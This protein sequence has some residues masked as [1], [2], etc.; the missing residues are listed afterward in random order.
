MTPQQEED[1]LDKS[2][3]LI[4]IPASWYLDD[5]PPMIFIKAAPNSHGFARPRHLGE[6]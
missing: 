2:T 5:L 1:V 3:D 4:E 6:T